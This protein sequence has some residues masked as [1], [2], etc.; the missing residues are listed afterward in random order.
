[1][2]QATQNLHLVGLDAG[3][4]LAF[5][6]ALGTLRLAAR[7]D[8][9]PRLSWAPQANSF[10]ST[11]HL[12]EPAAPDAFAA[13]VSELLEADF[14]DAPPAYAAQDIIKRPAPAFRADAS[15][16]AAGAT[17]SDRID[18][19]FFAGFAC[20][21]VVEDDGQVTPS[22]LSFANGQ[23]GKLLLR[24]YRDLA[25]DTTADDIE[26]AWF[27]PWA[28]TDACKTFRWD[29]S[30]LRY[31]A[32]RADNPGNSTVY[33]VRGGNTLAF[34]GLSML[35]TAPGSRGLAT[36]GVSRQPT[37]AKTSAWCFTWPVWDSPL[38]LDPLR[39]LLGLAEL[40]RPADRIPTQSLRDRGLLTAFRS[41]RVTYQKG[42]YLSRAQALF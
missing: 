6:A 3:N 7:I 33:G 16:A 30:D 35:P 36:T 39:G 5:M 25:V 4:P 2:T 1:M 42:L 27:R 8:A 28:Y 31:Y 12:S 10:R 13:A 40:Q 11:L 22:A 9:N 21:G 37:G 32:L 19:D 29:P 14:A 23:S 17:A 24:D 41:E 20:D 18:A 38:G 15:A 34:W 26:A